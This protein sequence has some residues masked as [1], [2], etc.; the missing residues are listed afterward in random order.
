MQ[1]TAVIFDLDGTL[2]RP[3]LDFDQIRAEIGGVEGP[4]LEAMEEMDAPE[5]QRAGDI[6]QRHEL[7]AA[8][9]SQLN[10]GTN[11]LLIY[12]QQRDFKVGVVT[13]NSR[14]SVERICRIHG[15]AFDAIVSREDGPAKPHPF[16][17]QQVCKIMEVTPQQ[18][19]VVGDYLFDLMSARRAG[20]VSV[21]ITTQK[22][23]SDFHGEADYV[24]DVLSELPEVMARIENK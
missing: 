12:L 10:R 2:T 19:V 13:R 15:L 21:L 23:H 9:N 6:L 5:R 11:E 14:D 22:N 17:V 20:A 7:D 8:E 24:I 3:Y 4:L 16:P 1:I 18:A